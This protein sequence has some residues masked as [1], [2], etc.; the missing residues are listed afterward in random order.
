MSFFRADGRTIRV[1]RGVGKVAGRLKSG[2]FIRMF[3]EE[4]VE[5]VWGMRVRGV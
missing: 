5:T 4:D 1:C 2:G 3:E